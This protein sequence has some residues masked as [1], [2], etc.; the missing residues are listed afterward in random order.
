MCGSGLY[1]SSPGRSYCKAWFFCIRITVF[2]NSVTYFPPWCVFLL[3]RCLNMGNTILSF[4][5][6]LSL[7]KF[8]S[9]SLRS[10]TF[11]CLEVSSISQPVERQRK[12]EYF[13]LA[14]YINSPLIGIS[15]FSIFAL[16]L[17]LDGRITD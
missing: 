17:L 16:S 12:L 14:P 2:H 8:W 5:N 10:Y 9:P 13:Y 11:H 15:L 1:F 4:L 3:P 6:L 7:L